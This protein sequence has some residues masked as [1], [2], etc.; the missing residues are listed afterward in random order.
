MV[1]IFAL[2]LLFGGLTALLIGGSDGQIGPMQAGQFASL[3]SLSAIAIWIGMGA[4]HKTSLS[5]NIR[6]AALWTGIFLAIG[7]VYAYRF[8]FISVKDRFMASLVPGTTSS[9]LIDGSAEVVVQRANDGQ[10]HI[11]ALANNQGV[12]FLLDTGASEIV[13]TASDAKAI[14]IDIDALR[15][16]LPVSTAAGMTT[17]ARVRIGS[18]SVGN[19]TR[20]NVNAMVSQ[21]QDLSKS[22]L[23]MTFLNSLSGFSFEGERVI[24]R[25]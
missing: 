14:G 4:F 21:P 8:E 5:Q 10:Y 23:G 19:I 18:L 24:L 1:I 20:N 12:S 15:Y 13:L 22:L 11:N 7:L 17:T 9:S 6:N 2:V 16:N 3:V 25:D